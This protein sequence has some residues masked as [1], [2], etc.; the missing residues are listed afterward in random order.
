MERKTYR[1]G[2]QRSL[3]DRS[4]AE[5][6]NRGVA[7][8]TKLEEEVAV[9]QRQPQAR[10]L[11]LE[12]NPF[13]IDVEEK[14]DRMAEQVGELQSRYEQEIQELDEAEI[15]DAS[16]VKNRVFD[17]MLPGHART[18]AENYVAAREAKEWE[19]GMN[20]SELDYQEFGVEEPSNDEAVN[21]EQEQESE[22]QAL[23][24]D[25]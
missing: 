13:L 14:E 19:L 5:D 20:L 3:M 21:L 8:D 6:F 25:Y 7:G 17:R 18:R 2:R 24:F 23:D 16:D 1:E 22:E 9:E 11:T 10:Y 15:A 12:P 4:S